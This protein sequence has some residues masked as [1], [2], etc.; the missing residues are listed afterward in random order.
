[1]TCGVSQQPRI[2]FRSDRSNDETRPY[3]L[4][5]SKIYARN[6]IAD[7]VAGGRVH[8]APIG[9]W[10]VL[11]ERGR[12][13]YLSAGE[14]V[15]FLDGIDRETPAIRALG[16]V[17][18][19]TGCRISEAIS[20]EGQHIDAEGAKLTIRT[21]KRRRLVFRTVPVPEFVIAMLLALNPSAESRIWPIHRVTAY[22]Q[23]KRVMT[24]AGIIGPMACCRG[25][26]HGYG[27]L[28]ASSQ[29]PPALITKW[30]GHANAATTA[31]YLDAVGWEERAF[32]GRMWGGPERRQ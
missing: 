6:P 1:M 5:A 25:L 17:L 13:K 12:R 29:V 16:Y 9:S 23:M 24:G 15:R 27:I 14:R 4:T 21:L 11:D 3:E 30:L 26:R 7:N 31:I 22:R 8:F 28:A 2:L 20:L 18:A 19:Y 10:Q 32:A